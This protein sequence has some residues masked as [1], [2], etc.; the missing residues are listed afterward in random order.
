MAIEVRKVDESYG[1]WNGYACEFLRSQDLILSD[2]DVRRYLKAYPFPK[3]RRYSEED[4]KWDL[5]AEGD[6]IIP[7]EKRETAEYIAE[8]LSRLI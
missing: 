3:D 5:Q 7:C 8:L 2:K 6:L 4:F 1:I